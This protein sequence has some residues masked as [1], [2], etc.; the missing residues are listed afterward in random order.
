MNWQN[1]HFTVSSRCLNNVA[2]LLI[3]L[4]LAT[5][6]E[7]LSN[8]KSRRIYD[9]GGDDL[10]GGSSSNSQR[11]SWQACINEVFAEF[12]NSNYEPVMSALEMLNKQSPGGIGL[13]RDAVRLALSHVR[14]FIMAGQIRYDLIQSELLELKQM[15]SGKRLSLF[16]VI[17]RM[18]YSLRITRLV[19]VVIRKSIAGPADAETKTDDDSNNN[20]NDNS[21]NEKPKPGRPPADGRGKENF[22]S[23]VLA[24]APDYSRSVTCDCLDGAISIIQRTDDGLQALEVFSIKRWFWQ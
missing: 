9:L 6:Y 23:S 19:L 12:M 8:P 20:R 14:Q 13:D 18:R 17:G 16:N 10:L 21:D 3:F 15:R 1:K 5:A 24:A 7:T 2:D 11:Q 4:G 22:E